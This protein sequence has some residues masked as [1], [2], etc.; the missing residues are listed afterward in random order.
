[1]FA[2]SGS[3]DRTSAAFGFRVLS[4]STESS[5]AIEKYTDCNTPSLDCH[6]SVKL[7]ID[8]TPA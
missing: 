4:E 7:L 1:M 2:V 5:L 6:L 8:N 3:L